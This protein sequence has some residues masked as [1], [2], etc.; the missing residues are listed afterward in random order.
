MTQVLPDHH[1]PPLGFK[2]L[3]P[4]YDTAIA[5]LTR[6]GRWRTEFVQAIDPQADD[7]IVDVGSG[8]GS[9]AAGVL[10]RQ[11]RCTY[12]GVDP[13][14]D[15][16][17]RAERKLNRHNFDAEFV[18]SYLESD[19][20]ETRP[21]PTKIISSLVLHQVPLNEKSRILRT[22]YQVLQPGGVCHIA[23]YGHQ[24]SWLSKSMFRLTVQ[25][26]DGISDTQPNA[27]GVLPK[28]MRA[29][30]FE[31]VLES[32]RIPTPT[33]VISLYQGVKSSALSEGTS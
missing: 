14:K 5:L 4:L 8:T 17:R 24:K 31:D 29:A 21:E 18:H 28:L 26:L 27:D 25:A 6:E 22:M 2:V 33:G 15:V 3:T 7:I 11:P 12:L 32:R 10:R 23:D 20:F 30:G 16:V 19:L 1:T 13:D 9:L